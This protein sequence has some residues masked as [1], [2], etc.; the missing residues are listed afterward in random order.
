MTALSG[1][2]T[3][4]AAFLKDIFKP[5]ASLSLASSAG[6]QWTIFDGLAQVR[7]NQMSLT[8]DSDIRYCSAICHWV[9]CP[10]KL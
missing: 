10:L 6:V 2:P 8:V 3:Y 4:S 1:R 7:P 5:M 9:L